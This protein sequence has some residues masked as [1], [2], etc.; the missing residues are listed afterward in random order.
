[1]S[2]IQPT[3]EST[4]PYY[5]T[6]VFC[7]DLKFPHDNKTFSKRYDLRLSFHKGQNNKIITNKQKKKK[8]D[9]RAC[10]QIISLSTVDQH[11]KYSRRISGLGFLQVCSI[12]VILCA[13][14]SGGGKVRLSEWSGEMDDSKSPSEVFH[15]HAP[16]PNPIPP[17][18]FSLKMLAGCW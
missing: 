8:T 5:N 3:K 14:E 13:G 4:C 2:Y 9:H 7:F 11:S 6:C 10:E 12:K 17:S 18:L 16:L 1:M 15:H